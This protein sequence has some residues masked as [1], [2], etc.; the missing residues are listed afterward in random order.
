MSSRDRARKR[1]AAERRTAIERVVSGRG[2]ERYDRDERTFHAALPHIGV[3][4]A[5]TMNFSGGERA[6]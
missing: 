2:G 4:N 1:A 6:K 5:L 3:G